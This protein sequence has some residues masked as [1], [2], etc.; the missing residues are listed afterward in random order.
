MPAHRIDV[1]GDVHGQLGALEA[2]GREL[3]YA[4]DDGWRHRD[5]R[6]LVFLGDLV[7]RGGESLEVARLVRR[8]EAAGRAVCLM[9]NHEY[10]LAAW[11]LAVPGYGRPKSSN[12]LTVHAIDDDPAPWRPILEWFATLPLGLALPDLRVIHA[13]WHRPSL[14]VV[15]PVLGRT[16]GTGGAQLDTFDWVRDH[17]VL[18]SPFEGRD[19]HP[20]LPGEPAD[21]KADL[22]HEILMKGPEVPWPSFSDNDGRPRDS[23]RAM[24]W[25]DGLDAVRT[26]RPQVF[27]HYWNCPPVHGAFVP[28]HPSG[29]PDLRAWARAWAPRCQGSG[30]APWDAELAC[31]DFQGVT[32]VSGHACVGAL[33]WP[34]AEIVWAVAEKTRQRR[35]PAR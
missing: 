6:V 11:H 23:A 8:L 13:C 25:R 3:G 15:E 16:P 35:R 14:A 17:V 32:R 28:P 20:D 26:D 2:L 4:V 18:R 19:L 31:V 1:I 30:R 12:H 33:R 24:W 34:E 21:P 7:D 9:G 5:G 10:N 29:H 27:G 22:P